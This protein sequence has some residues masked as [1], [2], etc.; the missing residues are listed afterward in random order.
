[1]AASVADQVQEAQADIDFSKHDYQIELDTSE[2][3]IVLDLDP[4]VAPGHVRNM[5][6]LAKIGFYDGVTFH[7]VIQG[8][9]IQGG[10]PQ[11]TGT[12]GPGYNIE[13]EF[14]KTP[15]TAG[16]LS[17]ARA[18]DPNSAGSQFFICLGTHTH[19][20][21]QYTAFGRTADQASLDVVRKIGSVPVGAADK[22]KKPVTIRSAKVHA[23]AK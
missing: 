8:F 7:R 9:M 21:C 3:P 10:C 19:L 13:A 18:A 15:H 12:G 14:N 2:G 1:M 6:A 17:M 23:K 22:P 4:Q 11:G 5:V 16:V 20:D